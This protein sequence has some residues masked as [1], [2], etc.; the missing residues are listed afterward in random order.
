M[1]TLAKC[2]VPA[3]QARFIDC[4]PNP[5]LRVLTPQEF[6]KRAAGTAR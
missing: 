1:N 6:S 5:F 2:I 4:K 3:A